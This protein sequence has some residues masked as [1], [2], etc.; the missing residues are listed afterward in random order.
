MKDA[1]LK[2]LAKKYS[3]IT[4]TQ[5]NEFDFGSGGEMSSA[6]ASGSSSDTRPIAALDWKLSGLYEPESPEQTKQTEAALKELTNTLSKLNKDLQMWQIKH[7]K[8]GANDTVSKEQLAQYIAKSI[9][10]ITKLD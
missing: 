2:T 3:L 8:L 7:T 10:G 4:E 1:G 5:V 6:D 9:L